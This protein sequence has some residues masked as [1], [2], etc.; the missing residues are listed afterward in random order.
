MRIIGKSARPDKETLLFLLLAVLLT[1]LV[2]WRPLSRGEIAYNFYS[3]F[4]ME[5]WAS[6]GYSAKKAEVAARALVGSTYELAWDP[7]SQFHPWMH[8]AATRLRQG[9]V[10]LW[11]P[12]AGAG[13]PLIANQQSAVFDPFHLL[14]Y[15]SPGL[16]FY[17]VL[18][19]L[20]LLW[21]ATFAFLF[22]RRVGLTRDGSFFAGGFMVFCSSFYPT[23]SHPHGRELAFLPALLWVAEK[24]AQERSG[25]A[26]SRRSWPC[27]RRSARRRPP[28][29]PSSA[30]GST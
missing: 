18:A 11:F 4:S 12:Y 16:R 25:R 29:T 26:I 28:S 19:A 2:L 9:A 23:W 27:R 20:R 24:Y 1:A 13:V 10:P 30:R 8:F 15:L 17:N 14:Y 21:A 22:A 5:P 6:A 3:V 7:E